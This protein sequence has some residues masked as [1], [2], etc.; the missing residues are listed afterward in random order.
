MDFS[1]D[2]ARRSEDHP[3]GQVKIVP[4]GHWIVVAMGGDEEREH[5]AMREDGE[6]AVGMERQGIRD[7]SAKAR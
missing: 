7:G 1:Q 5:R 6:V 2:E 3:R 4:E